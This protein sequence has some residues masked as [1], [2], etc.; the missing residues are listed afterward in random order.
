MC[1]VPQ[2]LV[3]SLFG[4]LDPKKRNFDSG[5]Y[6]KKVNKKRKRKFRIL[7]ILL[8]FTL[9]TGYFICLVQE[10]VPQNRCFHLFPFSPE[11]LDIFPGIW[12][13]KSNPRSL[14]QFRSP[15]KQRVKS[16]QLE[17]AA[18]MKL[19]LLLYISLPAEPPGL[20]IWSRKQ[21]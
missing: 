15:A 2:N 10:L 19:W 9:T 3:T 20:Y 12:Y 5:L 4:Y 8:S 18:N 14:T 6:R 13:R 16:G 7:L 11:R 21:L 17:G 1:E